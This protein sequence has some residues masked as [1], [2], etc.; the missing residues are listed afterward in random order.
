[1]KVGDLVESPVVEVVAPQPTPTPIVVTPVVDEHKL[2]NPDDP[3]SSPEETAETDDTISKKF[4]WTGKDGIFS[5][6]RERH[7]FLRG[8]RSGFGTRLFDKFDT[9]PAMWFDDAH[10]YESGQELG[11]VIKIGI[12]ISAVWIFTQLGVMYLVSGSD[13]TPV[14][15]AGN[16]SVSTAT[17]IIQNVMHLFGK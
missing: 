10:Y 3:Y 13:P 6:W 9:C 17:T 14:I 2:V 11:Y 12:Q 8:F 7:I 1:M 16:T 5:T 15:A 4:S